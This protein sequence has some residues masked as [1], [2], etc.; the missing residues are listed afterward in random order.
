MVASLGTAFT[1]TALCGLVA[2][3]WSSAASADS[4]TS[5][6][7]A[8][9]NTASGSAPS[10]PVDAPP[11]PHKPPQAAFDACKDASEGAACSVS[12]HGHT[13]NGTCKKGPN[14]ETDLA[15][16][17][18]HPPGDHPPGPPPDG[19]SE[20]IGSSELEHKLDRLE[21]SIQGQR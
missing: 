5:Q 9:A 18:E 8:L 20:S 15:C 17:P 2:Y 21:K 14:G 1:F 10:Q 4:T 3:G 6:A 19:S 16:V 7:S 12:F 11:P 13:M